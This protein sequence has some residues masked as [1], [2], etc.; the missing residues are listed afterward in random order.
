MVCLK[1]PSSLI[2]SGEPVAYPSISRLVSFEAE[3]GVVI[4]RRLRRGRGRSWT[5][6]SNRTPLSVI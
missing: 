1:T 5:A 4:G 6:C 2:A 3:L